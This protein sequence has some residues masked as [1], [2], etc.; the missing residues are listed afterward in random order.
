MRE[1]RIPMTDLPPCDTTPLPPPDSPVEMPVQTL[2]AG[3][4]RNAF[5]PTTP[6]GMATR[7]LAVIGGA[8]LLTLI[9]TYQIWWVLRGGG[10]D[11]LEGIRREF[12]SPRLRIADRGLREGI[13]LSLMRED[14]VLHRGQGA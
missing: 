6:R 13:L 9:A 12:P 4:L 8:A 7:R 1:L 11:I 10:I 3:E 5:L 14:G 2:R